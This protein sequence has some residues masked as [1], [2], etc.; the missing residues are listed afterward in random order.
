MIIMSKKVCEN[1]EQCRPISVIDCARCEYAEL[2]SPKGF[3]DFRDVSGVYG[4]FDALTICE[5][6]CKKGVY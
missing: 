4:V 6:K 1:M 5:F 2:I 3:K